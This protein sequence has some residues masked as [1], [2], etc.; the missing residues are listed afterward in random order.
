MLLLLNLRVRSPATNEYFRQIARLG[1][2]KIF[3]TTLA[4]KLSGSYNSI[5]SASKIVA[6]E[7]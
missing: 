7:I 6:S 1:Y 3:V 2:K 4:S 5:L